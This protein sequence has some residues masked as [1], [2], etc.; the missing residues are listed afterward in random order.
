MASS[1]VGIK[2]PI[3]LY[4]GA[5][6]QMPIPNFGPDHCSTEPRTKPALG[7]FRALEHLLVELVH[8]RVELF[9]GAVELALGLRL[10]LLVLLL[11]LGAVL[12]ELLLSLLCLSPCLVG[13]VILAMHISSQ[14][15][16]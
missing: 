12:V 8:G 14:T 2:N 9:A 10:C 13:L 16:R 4:A 6:K 15:L 11:G 3:P 5:K 7:L 1:Y